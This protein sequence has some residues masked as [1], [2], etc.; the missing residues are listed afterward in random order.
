[1]KATF[2]YRKSHREVKRYNRKEQM[3]HFVKKQMVDKAK[4]NVD[5]EDKYKS[6]TSPEVMA[7]DQISNVSKEA[8]YKAQHKTKGILKD[9]IPSFRNS[10][11]DKIYDTENKIY[12]SRNRVAKI[13]KINNVSSSIDATHISKQSNLNGMKQYVINKAKM[14]TLANKPMVIKAKDSIVKISNEVIKKVLASNNQL[15]LGGA[16]CLLLVF[17]LLFG[18]FASLS[19]DSSIISAQEVLSAEVLAYEDTIK[20]Y[21]KE[22]NIEDY[23]PIIEAIMMQESTGKG[24]DPM[25][26][27]AC[28]FNKE[29]PDGITDP[30]Y[31]IKVGIQYY[32]ECLKKANVK[33]VNDEKGIALSL[34]GYNYGNGYIEWAL[35]NFQGYTKANAKVFSD[36]QK[37]KLKTTTYGD[38]EYVDHVLRYVAF[39][40]GNL[41]GNPN[42]NNM[43]AWVSKNPYAQAG[44]YG[45][46]TWFAWGRFYEIYGYSPGFTGNG[47]DCVN[48]LVAAHPDKFVKSNKPS[49]GAIF[50]T[51]GHN[52]VGIVVGWD[53]T[54]I[55][56]QEGNLDGYTNTFAQ[57]KRDWQTKT[58]TINQFIQINGGVI[59]AN[60][61]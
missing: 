2:S 39:G 21:A 15:A 10:R 27:S 52:H 26:S 22:Y 38:P 1:M 30:E 43:Q 60:A 48:Q 32:A 24:D 47:S 44:L 50:S 18:A 45:Q 31:S 58:Y 20:K 14:T 7:T 4:R 35:N 16:I 36:M 46:C 61:K 25:Q 23:V 19:S 40:F 6:A 9:R 53:G 57:A 54:N 41:R 37:D 5:K 42:F 13:N 34:Q 3:N 49:V 8:A 55:T 33:D 51:L 29:Y 12:S 59:F 28:P 17:S 56:I 11:Q